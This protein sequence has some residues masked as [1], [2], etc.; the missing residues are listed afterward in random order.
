M[1]AKRAAKTKITRFQ[2]KKERDICCLK[3]AGKP[4]HQ[5]RVAGNL[6]KFRKKRARHMIRQG[7]TH[8]VCRIEH[9]S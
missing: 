5:A 2:G 8:L 3:G 7:T 6:N 4:R 9:D 1:L